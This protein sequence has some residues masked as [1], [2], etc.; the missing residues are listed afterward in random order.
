MKQ[1]LV[2]SVLLAV[3][4]VAVAVPLVATAQ[5]TQTWY[6]NDTDLGGDNREMD[7]GTPTAASPSEVADY[8]RIPGGAGASKRWYADE[9]ATVDVPF[10]SGSWMGPLYF[11]SPPPA[12]TDKIRV[13]VGYMPGFNYYGSQDLS[14]NGT[15]T[16]FFI[17]FTSAEFTV[18]QGSYLSYRV[19]NLYYG[20]SP[21]DI[22]VDTGGGSQ[23]SIASPSTD[24]GYPVSEL[25]TIILLA[26]G[27]VGLAVYLGFKRRKRVI[28]RA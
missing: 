13:E 21:P 23:S 9:A 4:L 19:T 12:G 17:N 18:P 24:P 16:L 3:M 20:A 25:P 15:Q 10:P 11:M 7:K 14:P 6:L 2:V 8:V 22:D 28:V 1:R 26:T 27:L 5:S